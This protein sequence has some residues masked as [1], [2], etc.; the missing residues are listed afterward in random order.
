M[1]WPSVNAVN[2]AFAFGRSSPRHGGVPGAT[3]ARSHWAPAPIVL[4][5]RTPSRAPG[6][7]V[8][9]TLASHAP[10]ASPAVHVP[11]HPGHPAARQPGRADPGGDADRRRR[12][13]DPRGARP[14]VAGATGL[15][16]RGPVRRHRALL[17]RPALGR[18]RAGLA[19]GAPGADP[20]PRAVA[21]ERL[22]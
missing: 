9:A 21:G 2:R 4:G 16:A 11:R 15:R 17:G 1:A 3:T 12:H 10:G 18:A 6:A 8:G 13:P 19:R 20:A 5:A 22:T 7:R 14:L